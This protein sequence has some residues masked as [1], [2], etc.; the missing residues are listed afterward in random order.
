MSPPT[1]SFAKGEYASGVRGALASGERGGL[2]ETQ[3]VGRDVTPPPTFF[4]FFYFL[5]SFLSFRSPFFLLLDAEQGVR[6]EILSPIT[7]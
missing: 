5:C 4:F 6:V 7:A 2:D 3:P 1:C